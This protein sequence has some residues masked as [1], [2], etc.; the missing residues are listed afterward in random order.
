[1]KTKSATQ[2]EP[3]SKKNLGSLLV[4]ISTFT[5]SSSGIFTSYLQTHFSLTPVALAFWRD[6]LASLILFIVIRSRFPKLL[7]QIKKNLKF[8]ILFGFST[9]MFNFVWSTSIKLNGA[10]IS[11]ILTY[12][13]PTFT[14]IISFLLFK[15]KL[16]KGKI[17]AIFVGFFGAA[18][19]SGA[20]GSDVWKTNILG[21]L[22]GL[23]SG[24]LYSF[25]TIFGEMAAKKGIH[26]L[27][28]LLGSFLFASFFLLM[29]NFPDISNLFSFRNSAVAWMYLFILVIFPTLSGYGLYM[30]SLGMISATTANMISSLEP[31]FTVLWSVIFLGESISVLQIA[32]GIL[33]LFS[34]LFIHANDNKVVQANR[35]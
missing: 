24:L 9:A 13:S 11:A 4:L 35:K 22:V 27:I 7:V 20:V 32:G 6:F 12:S 17:A 25:Y 21:I 19:V 30:F 18:L 5:W 1:M 8:L 29:M 34:V 14:A 10:A 15:E 2:K 16:G 28:A 26:P 33:I 23:G 31:F 3:L